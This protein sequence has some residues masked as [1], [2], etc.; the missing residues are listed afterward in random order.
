MYAVFICLALSTLV[1]HSAVGHRYYKH[2]IAFDYSLHSHSEKEI[3]GGDSNL[4]E[5]K[6]YIPTRHEI[7]FPKKND[8]LT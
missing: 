7:W 4:K 6:N 2:G 1:G 5:K 3:K 8:F